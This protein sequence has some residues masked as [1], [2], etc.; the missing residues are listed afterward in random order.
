[1]QDGSGSAHVE[2]RGSAYLVNTDREV[3]MTL[4]HRSF[5]KIGKEGANVELKMNVDVDAL[6]IT[7]PAV[8]GLVL[9]L[10]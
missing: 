10:D 3:V 4:K 5:S 6:H 7:I 9:H 2:R 8:R 1:M